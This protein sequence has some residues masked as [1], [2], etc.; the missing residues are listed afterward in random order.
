[1]L[2]RF[3]PVVLCVTLLSACVPGQALRSPAVGGTV[4]NRRTGYPV[5]GAEVSIIRSYENPT[6]PA[7][8]SSVSDAEGH[9]SMAAQYTFGVIPLYG[10]WRTPGVTVRV[11]KAGY[12]NFSR[13]EPY[14]LVLR[15]FE[16]I[17][18]DVALDPTG[19]AGRAKTIEKANSYEQNFR[20]VRRS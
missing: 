5:A 8:A 7:L 19:A 10:D 13:D 20:R 3:L 4:T 17:R 6:A 15:P 9:Y 12:Q 18:S 2:K 11:S 16:P 1:M 14:N